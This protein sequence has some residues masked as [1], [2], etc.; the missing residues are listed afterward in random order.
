MADHVQFLTGNLQSN[1]SFTSSVHDWE[2]D[3]VTSF[4]DLLHYLKLKQSGKDKMCLIPSKRQKFE[5]RSFY[6]ALCTLVGSP[7]PWKSI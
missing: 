5:V 4:F 7:F 6:H 2:V 1:F 3:L